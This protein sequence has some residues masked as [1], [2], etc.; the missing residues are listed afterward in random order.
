MFE[1]VA[2]IIVR[3]LFHL[4]LQSSWGKTF[5]FFIYDT[6]KIS[7]LLVFIILLMGVVN[8]YFPVERIRR[9]LN[10]RK[11]WGIENFL[12]STLGALTP[13]CSCSSIP[14][15]IGFLKGGIPL[16]VTLSFLI[17]SPLVNEVALAIFWGIFGTKVTVVYAVSGILL[18][19]IVGRLLG[20][21]NLDRYLQDWVQEL[22]KQKI[23][24]S[25]EDAKK[26]LKE[27][28]P[29]IWQEAMSVF[30]RVF[31]YVLL[32]LS[33]GAVIHGHVPAGYFE[34]Y[35]TRDNM[36][37]VP[38]ATLLAVPMYANATGIIPVVQSLVSKGIPL[39]TALA[40]MMGVVGLS[41]PEA[42]L[43][44]K[45]MKI[46]LIVIYFGTVACAIMLIGFLFNILF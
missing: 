21:L 23:Q 30:K 24:D 2:D 6:L 1:K 20:F 14:L 31:P 11:L 33:I 42:L 45:V 25:A 43:L 44:K 19:T 8:S 5:H 3:D 32:G 39:G 4:G 40:F 10:G 41:L 28:L 36:F 26:T 22:V 37:A 12:A 13:F 38:V 18:G 34:Q 9:F 35:I 46:K 29:E 15:F 27:R 16:G 17:T 7:F